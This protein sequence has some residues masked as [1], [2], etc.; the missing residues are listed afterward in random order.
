[1]WS[2]GQHTAHSICLM[3]FVVDVLAM[4]PFSLFLVFSLITDAFVSALRE[5][6]SLPNIFQSIDI[7]SVILF[8]RPSTRGSGGEACIVLG[9]RRIGL[10]R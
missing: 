4:F 3:E 8:T 2:A 10:D 1:M 5:L 9:V 7:I 6:L